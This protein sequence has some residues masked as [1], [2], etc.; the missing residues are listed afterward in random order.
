MFN[1]RLAGDPLYWKLLFTWLSLVTSLVVSCFVQS[2]SPRNVLDEIWTK[3]SQFLRIFPTY[4]DYT[5]Y[6]KNNF[7]TL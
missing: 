7:D 5:V 6:T 1:V 3:L 2:F 4:S